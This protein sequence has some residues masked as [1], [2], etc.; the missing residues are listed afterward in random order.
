MARARGEIMEKLLFYD[1]APVSYGEQTFLPIHVSSLRLDSVPQFDIYYRP[2]AAQP[3][4]L[5]R[6]RSLPFGEVERRRLL[7]NKV[8]QV[9][10]L[11]EQRAEYSRYVAQHLN[12]ILAD[13]RLSPREKSV[14]L[15]DSAQTV[16]QDVLSAP[17]SREHVERGKEVARHT[18][19]FINSEE[20]L[21]E[22]L[23]RTISC[24]YYLYTHSVNVA[25]FSV[26]LAAQAGHRDAAT[27]REVANGALLH[28]VGK[29]GMPPEI[30][31]KPGALTPEEWSLV[32]EH[33]RRGHDMM[34][35][36]GG[37]G[38]I[39]LDIILHHHERMDGSGYP[40]GLR[41]GSISPFVRMVAIADVFDALT[42]DRFHQKGKTTFEAIQ[43]MQRDMA[44]TL[45]AALLR[46]FIGLMGNRPRPAH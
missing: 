32:Q 22:Q 3:F 36:T 28:D 2:G 35:K 11:Q 1:A 34:R 45:D 13:R 8:E 26:A 17:E 42:V 46:D 23:L 20:F 29:A 16:V 21:L 44:G 14:I 10:I 31:N 30:L 24:D 27:L 9:Y 19:D 25:A 39:A 15:Y 43:I 38:E 12:D 5:Y 18:V 40:D 41:D 7:D 37:L 33:P 6:Q 4:V